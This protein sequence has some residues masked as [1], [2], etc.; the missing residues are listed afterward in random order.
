MTSSTS[1]ITPAASDPDPDRLNRTIAS[2][3]VP[4]L[5]VAHRSS[6]VPPALLCAM[7]QRL[8]L[9]QIDRFVALV[10]GTDDAEVDAY[11]AG[12]IEAG[13]TPEAVY[14]DLLAP[15]ARRLGE[16]WVEDACD[17]MEVTVSVGRLQRVLRNL[18]HL[19]TLRSAAAEPVGRALLACVTGEQH[20]LGLF[21]VAEFFVREGWTVEV[22]AP[23]DTGDVGNRL[24][25]E[26]FDL[27]G[28]SVGCET[29]L[30]RLRREVRSVRR[31]SRNPRIITM[32]GGRV[33][34]E[35]PEL[36]ARVGADRWAKDASEAPS[37]ARAALS[38]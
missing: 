37:V 9:E 8:T 11:V 26:W 18:S 38:A 3:L 7:G 32:V 10:R 13:F 30:S 35:H 31:A 33:F 2:E 29:H 6:P 34:A 1:G 23:L 16:M 12:V 4:R 17:F 15:T 25:D 21:M 36:V 20:T 22:G 24:R 5:M 19:F 14:L 28:F 27:V